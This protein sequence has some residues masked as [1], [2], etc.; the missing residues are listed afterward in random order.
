MDYDIAQKFQPYLDKSETVRWTGRPKQGLTFQSSDLFF[1]PFS[2]LWA[3]FAVFW[4]STVIASGAPP[5]FALW[6]VPFVLVGLYITVGRFFFEAFVRA[7]TYYA[8]T[9]KSAL[10]LGGWAGNALTSVDLRSLG[11]L[12]Y[13]PGA[14]DRGTIIL[15]PDSMA[16]GIPFARSRYMPNSPAF[17]AV[18]DASSAYA[19]IQQQ[20]RA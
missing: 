8:L 4:E 11:E 9:D 1:V 20:R 15:G 14:G 17:F 13:K 2:L 3:G 16:R 10:I 18:E 7:R 12:N 5:F 19:L 6:G